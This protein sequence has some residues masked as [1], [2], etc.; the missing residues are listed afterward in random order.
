MAPK[1][2]KSTPTRN[3][4][5]GFESSSYDSHIPL[6]IR[7]RDEKTRKDFSENFQYHG[8][9]LE[10]QVILSDFAETHLTDVIR[11]RGWASLLKSPLRC[12]IV[13][14]QEFYSNIH[15]IDINVPQFI[16]TFK[17]THIVVTPESYIRGITY[18]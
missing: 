16:T 6:H 2:C 7:F 3:P 15:D 17:G 11:S 4:L 8:V 9:H 12:L 13:F 14:I 1:V 5:Q 18:S 10:C